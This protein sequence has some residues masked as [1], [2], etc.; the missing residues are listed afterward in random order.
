MPAPE[1]NVD[2]LKKFGTVK[3]NKHFINVTGENKKKAFIAKSK[4]SLQEYDEK[5]GKGDHVE[6][7]SKDEIKKRHLGKV[8]CNIKFNS[9]DELVKLL[10]SYFAD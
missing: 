1:I 9:E 4:V 8:K 5:Y 2:T 7:F 10:T 6:I 3:K